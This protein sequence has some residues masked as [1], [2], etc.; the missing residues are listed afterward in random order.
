MVIS[1]YCLNIDD[2]KERA[3]EVLLDLS[4]GFPVF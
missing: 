4:A 1:D 3:A 2:R